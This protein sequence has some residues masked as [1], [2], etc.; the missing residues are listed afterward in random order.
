MR[1]PI[2]QDMNH[3]NYTAVILHKE[4]I[5][6]SLLEISPIKSARKR[7]RTGSMTELCYC[8]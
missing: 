2:F 8:N 1:K 3:Y 5:C 4:K 6:A 7:D